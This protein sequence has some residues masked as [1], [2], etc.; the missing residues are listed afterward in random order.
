MAS[1]IKKIITYLLCVSTF[2]ANSAVFAETQENTNWIMQAEKYWQQYGFEDTALNVE[3]TEHDITRA[4]FA[5]L[6]NK[7]FKFSVKSEKKFI[8]LS[9]QS[10]YYDD[11]LTA[12]EIG[13]I[14]GY[15][16]NTVRPDAKLT[17]QEAAAIFDR[18][19][20][21][22]GNRQIIFYDEN[23]IAQWAKEPV[24]NLT[25]SGVISG[26]DNGNF[27]PDDN[28]NITQTFTLIE[29][30][31]KYVN[32]YEKQIDF[33]DKN[34]ALF[35]ENFESAAIGSVPKG[36]DSMIPD[37][38]K[39]VTD[40][41]NK[42]LSV[43]KTPADKPLFTGLLTSGGQNHGGISRFI[44]PI[45][46]NVTLKFR[47]KTN[48]LSGVKSIPKIN[49]SKNSD[50][51]EVI[52]NNDTLMANSAGTLESLGKIEANV[53]YDVRIDI[54]T[55]EDCYDFYLNGELLKKGLSFM[56]PSGHV[57]RLGFYVQ[58]G[59]NGTLSVDDII[60]YN[61][62]R[63]VN[64]E[65]GEDGDGY[66]FDFDTNVEEEM[67]TWD[68]GVS[69]EDSFV[70]IN[71]IM[72]SNS[73]Y[74]KLYK[75]AYSTGLLYAQK[76]FDTPF[77]GNI[78]LSLKF[79]PE[80][81]LSD[82][83]SIFI[84]DQSIRLYIENKDLKLMTSA[85]NKSIKTSLKAKQWYTLKVLINNDKGSYDVYVDDELCYGGGTYA[86][87]SG[88]NNILFAMDTNKRG[89]L[90]IDD[91][92][93]RNIG[94][95]ESGSYKP[96]VDGYDASRPNGIKEKEDYISVNRADKT[97]LII[98][99]VNMDS[100]NMKRVDTENYNGMIVDTAGAGNVST[101]FDGESGRYSINVGYFGKAVKY[102]TLYNMYING[103]KVDC[104]I[105]Q[106]DDD[107]LHVR[108]VK[109]T[110]QLNTGDKI[111][112]EGYYGKNQSGVAYL[113]ID[114]PV[115]TTEEFGHL[116][117]ETYLSP[118]YFASSGWT[119]DES[120]GFARRLWYYDGTEYY[121]AFN[122]HDISDVESVTAERPFLEQDSGLIDV[123]FRCFIEKK[124]DDITWSIRSGEREV[125]TLQTKNGNLCYIDNDNNAVVLLA[126][127]PVNKQFTVKMKVNID[128]KTVNIMSGNMEN[129]L[130]NLPFR[131]DAESID[132]FYV[133]T[134][135]YATAHLAFTYLDIAHG[136]IV[137]DDF[138]M[139]QS[140]SA[141]MDWSFTDKADV[142]ETK[143]EENDFSSVILDGKNQ[144]AKRVF[145]VQDKR[146]TW[147]FN[148]MQETASDG[149]VMALLDGREKKLWLETR[150][151]NL[152]VKYADKEYLVWENYLDNM[153]YDVSVALDMEKS[154]LSVDVNGID[155]LTEETLGGTITKIDGVTYQTNESNSLLFD[156]VEIFADWYTSNVP[157][158]Q[159][160][161]TGDITIATQACDIWNEGEH[162]GW[163]CIRD[164][165]SRVPFIGYYS[166]GNPEVADWET[167]FL[168][169]HGVSMYFTCFY[170]PGNP[171]KGEA[172]KTPGNSAKLHKGFFN[173][174]Y[175]NDMKF[176][177]I[178][179][180]TVGLSG[181]NPEE[182][183][184]NNIVR[185][186][187]EHYFKNPSY[188]TFN[189]KPVVSIWNHYQFAQELGG[190]EA[191]RQTLEKA[192]KMAKDAGF[193]GIIFL[194]VYGGGS[195]DTEKQIEARGFDYTYAYHH[196]SASVE[197]QL[198]LLESQKA[199]GI[200]DGLGFVSQGWGDEA[201]GR[202]TRKINTDPKEYCNA[203]EWIKDYYI[204]KF[205]PSSLASSM[206]LLGN[207]NEIAEGHYI[208]PSNIYGF[209]YL[210]AI[211]EVFGTN[212]DE[213]EHN[214]ILPKDIGLG[215][216]DQKTPFLWR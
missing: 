215:P 193:D 41:T 71:Q 20:E 157:E 56:L 58:D 137:N 29:N 89:T 209:A 162:F 111:V 200:I 97:G 55:D 101:T 179:E 156:D 86:V 43:E 176:G 12:V 84:A 139:Y 151:G 141:V 148:W 90:A 133:E 105:S 152:Y 211:R 106:N 95:F 80:D 214:D 121:R 143:A 45:L 172:I 134:P 188:Y 158:P 161:D 213:V 59:S 40:G 126:D 36:W 192:D 26:Y 19:Y 144:E 23:S 149:A 166:D 9:N 28:L 16:D 82:W 66:F 50:L 7:A 91:L 190:D 110:Y 78:E 13:Y 201:W 122:L 73:H 159:K 69:G 170:R 168:L 171:N 21:F 167:K 116:V 18:L 128:N 124:A 5:A 52:I 216:Y 113:Q 92:R 61:G 123:E 33:S 103:K 11:M 140:G 202:S 68:I 72:D 120:G 135:K 8:D 76:D 102:D 14:Q 127:Y 30:V 98:D 136:Y 154:L 203:L 145:D 100:L 87:K 191:C 199:N 178:F 138:K 75:P 109:S 17:R 114:Q 81:C 88:I 147:N 112:I 67:A 70:G 183:F 60:I 186:W 94:Y 177:I 47:F 25:A 150:N 77:T 130:E 185:Y 153:W 37:T 74:L 160:V 155:K 62:P 196:N 146:L 46:G 119:V 79:K 197:E 194:T 115:E 204:T 49:D 93:V 3:Y 44:D 165:D 208:M 212:N 42:Y 189:N 99:A 169:E 35:E 34:R 195:Y 118:D 117:E 96:E 164:I 104:W 180:N 63:L 6:I 39:V 198:S 24:G 32:E 205:Q 31:K 182:D 125:F 65:S 210:D 51:L 174:N 2:L 27:G 4:E 181:E 206:L 85:G 54:D 163:Q 175:K 142:C 129:Y 187:I 173:S 57:G 53:W 64:S 132:N 22:E 83:K 107:I 131:F 15:D 184:L 207:W 38:V 48:E 108:N 1:R 10:W